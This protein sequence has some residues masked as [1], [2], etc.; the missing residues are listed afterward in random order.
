MYSF[1]FLLFRMFLTHMFS[2]HCHF[3]M[4]ISPPP[5]VTSE[6]MARSFIVRRSYCM[7][8]VIKKSLCTVFHIVIIRCTETFWSPR[9]IDLLE[10]RAVIIIVMYEV[11]SAS[12]GQ[13]NLHEPEILDLWD[14]AVMLFGDI[15]KGVWPL[16]SG[17]S[18][19]LRTRVELPSHWCSV[20]SQKPWIF[21][22]MAVRTLKFC[23]WCASLLRLLL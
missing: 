21:S 12:L 9:I 10:C 15:L 2:F 16:S 20:I 22:Y 5:P 11:W 23:R 18:S 14:L 8:R 4:F 13:S 6:T 7:C 1:Q 3:L 17:S 19:I